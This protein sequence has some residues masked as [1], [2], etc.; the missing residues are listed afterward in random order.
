MIT[1][2]ICDHP[3]VSLRTSIPPAM[4]A[5]AGILATAAVLT[6]CGCPSSPGRIAAVDRPPS[7][8]PSAAAST[9]AEC[10]DRP[11]ASGDIL[12]RITTNG[13][14]A[15]TQQF[16][17]AWTWNSRSHRCE[18]PVQAVLSTASG[19]AG[20]CTQVAYVASNPGYRLAASP[21]PPLKKVVAAKGPAC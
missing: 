7:P 10:E 11:D 17:G 9:R 8:A 20:S 19:N 5:L 18:T 14:P 2:G 3:A 16:G 6:G 13:Q 4:S 12:V 21:A 15:V 1:E